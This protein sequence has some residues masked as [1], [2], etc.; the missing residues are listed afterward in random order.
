MELLGTVGYGGFS[1][2]GVASKSGVARATLYRRFRDKDALIAD[3]LLEG[4][5]LGPDNPTRPA[6]VF[7][8]GLAR[9]A[10]SN[11]GA[12]VQPN[13]EAILSVMFCRGN[14]D[15]GLRAVL[16]ARL[17]AALTEAV[18]SLTRSGIEH[19]EVRDTVD[20]EVIVDLLIGAVLAR[21]GVGLDMDDSWFEAVV[22]TICRG[23]ETSGP[24]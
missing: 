10:R 9:I 7:R 3:A 24:L 21:V 19:G 6:E 22:D 17:Y 4:A 18:R 15:P 23:A 16:R 12:M 1:M 13:G 5:D 20:P 2:A 11:A 8:D 14:P